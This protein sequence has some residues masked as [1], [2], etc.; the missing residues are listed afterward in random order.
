MKAQPGQ[1]GTANAGTH[2]LPPWLS[3]LGQALLLIFICCRLI[4]DKPADYAGQL[5]SLLAVVALVTWQHPLRRGMLV[6][7]FLAALATQ[8]VTWGLS[9]ALAPEL[10]ERSPKLE[11]LAAWFFL[12]PVALFMGVGQGRVLLWW[13]IA[14]LALLLT[15]WLS[16]QG[17]SEIARGLAGERVDFG[18]V[19][20]QHP[21]MLFGLALLGTTIF[22]PRFRRYTRQRGTPWLLWPYLLL[23]LVLA[24]GVVI[25][26]TR[27]VWLGLLVTLPGMIVIFSGYMDA[28]RKQSYLRALQNSRWRMR[29][30]ALLLAL[31]IPAFFGGIV[32]ERLAS[33]GPLA[34]L[35]GRSDTQP[36]LKENISVRLYTWRESLEWIAQRPLF[37]WGGSGRGEVV[38]ATPELSKQW[39]RLYGHLHSSYLDTLVNFGFAG[40]LVLLGLLYW[41]NSRVMLA[42]RQASI[43]DDFLWFWLAFLLYWLVLNMFESY[44]Y[45][46]T[47]NY[48]FA[49]IC[50]GYAALTSGSTTH[51]GRRAAA[52]PGT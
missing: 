20:A 12:I 11:R 47:G 26:Q 18:I 33:E 19:N 8:L 5:L 1:A 25:T 44:M 29:F 41:L 17:W 36:V 52:S 28:E 38:E 46:Q 2:P 35:D 22:L 31:M 6:P 39:K 34:S 7:L 27:G 3:G 42:W 15:P 48:A 51:R 30:L 24:T 49:L 13:S 50:G 16:G 4:S 45:Y 40:L 9:H 32:L 10:A 37:G 43:S 14:L 21:A 23:V